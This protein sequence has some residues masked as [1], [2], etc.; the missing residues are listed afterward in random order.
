VRRVASSWAQGEQ[1]EEEQPGEQ[2]DVTRASYF[3]LDDSLN[4]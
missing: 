4:L 3:V 2:A 1:A